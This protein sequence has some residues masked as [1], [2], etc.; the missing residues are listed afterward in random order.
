MRPIKKILFVCAGN[1]C[2]SPFAAAFM[3]DRID[4][5]GL[6]DIAVDSAGLIALPGNTVTPLAQKVALEH[7]VDLSAHRAKPVSGELLEWADLILVMEKPQRDELAARYPG[8]QGRCL[9]L[10]HF[11]RYGS[12]TRGIADPYGLQYESYR[13][14]FLDIADA[15]SGLVAYLKTQERRYAVISVQC[16]EGMSANESP[17]SFQWEGKDHE[18][19][20]ILDRW[21]A[22]DRDNTDVNNY[23]RVLCKDGSVH[24]LRYNRLFDQWAIVLPEET[25]LEP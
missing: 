3:K 2:R 10:R 18:I 12:R 6:E 22:T 4:R 19:A 17:R 1:I 20:R 21:Y 24:L 8:T 14:C 5:E 13:F 23:F 16:Y 7:D 15:V 25:R 11:A 9:L